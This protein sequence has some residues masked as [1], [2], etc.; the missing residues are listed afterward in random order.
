MYCKTLISVAILVAATLGAGAEG[1]PA[2]QPPP[3]PTLGDVRQLADEI[4]GDKS[5]LESY[6]SLGKLHDEMQQAIENNDLDAIKA[7]TE[8]TNTLEQM[9]GPEY[10]MVIDGLDQVDLN[11]AEGQQ[12]ADVFKTLQ[13]KCE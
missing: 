11:T 9:L 8:R 7:L 10:D 4:A 2:D 3:K 6:C 1:E 5:K 13:A 12:L